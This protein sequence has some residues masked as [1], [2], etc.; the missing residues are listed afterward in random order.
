V[1]NALA[2]QVDEIRNAL[3]NPASITAQAVAEIGA[4]LGMF[5]QAAEESGN[6]HAMIII[7]NT[8]DVVQQADNLRT[9]AI[10]AVDLAAEI[11][12]QRAAAV[13][14]LS[15]LETAIAEIDLSNDKI[16]DFY[17][18]VETSIGDEMEQ[19]TYEYLSESVWD[20]LYDGLSKGIAEATGLTKFEHGHF[21][22]AML[23]E[24]PFTDDEAQVLRA[25]II[26]VNTRIA[27]DRRLLRE[28]HNRRVAAISAG[29]GR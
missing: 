7:A 22:D 28:E 9:T 17:N 11:E 8:W 4:Q 20:E 18:E 21:I 23:N 27:E 14:Q 15:E 6:Q 25:L 19:D 29:Q 16:R 5:Y 3:V 13:A 1:S 2:I 26:Q 24:I 12:Q 10:S